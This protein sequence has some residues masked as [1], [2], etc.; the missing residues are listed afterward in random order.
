M[1]VNKRS[2]SLGDKKVVYVP[3]F[4]SLQHMK[5]PSTIQGGPAEQHITARSTQDLKYPGIK[6]YGNGQ[7]KYIYIHSDIICSWIEN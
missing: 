1:N 7:T 5:V 6:T 3:V 4:P 2:Q